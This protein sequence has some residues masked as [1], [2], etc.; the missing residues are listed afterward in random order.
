MVTQLTLT[1]RDATS[2]KTA[3]T[4]A[5]FLEM[6][7]SSD[8][9]LLGFPELSNIGYSVYS[10]DDGVIWVSFLKLGVSLL[11]EVPGDGDEGFLRCIEPLVLEGPAVETVSAFN[12]SEKP[13]QWIADDG[14]PGVRVIEGPARQGVNQIIVAIEPGARAVLTGTKTHGVWKPNRR[15]QWRWLCRR[16]P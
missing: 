10:D 4:D 11:A 7:N 5:C 6:E 15:S 2:D 14:W 9:L 12:V 8:A 16:P 3:M 1:F 13:N